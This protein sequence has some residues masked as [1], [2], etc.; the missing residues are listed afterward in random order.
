MWTRL[1]ARVRAFFQSPAL[2]GDFDQEMESHL[3]ML[4]EDN[5]RRGMTPQ[6]ARRQARLRLGG[7]TQLG[8]A[9]REHR[10]LPAV[11]T[12]LQH[13]VCSME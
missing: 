13:Q 11:E 3:A 12:L 8:E 5:V 9:H 7:R 1:A 2:D 10:G 6:E 4:T